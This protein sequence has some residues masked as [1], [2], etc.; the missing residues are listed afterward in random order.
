MKPS[1]L[2]SLLAVLATIAACRE[3]ERSD[4]APSA[5]AATVATPAAPS[6]VSVPPLDLNTPGI[7]GQ[8]FRAAWDAPWPLHR[9]V[10]LD[11]A[12]RVLVYEEAGLVPLGGDRY[13]LISSGAL[14]DAGHVDAGALSI[15]YLKYTPA[16][17]ERTGAWPEFTWDG[18]FGN[19]PTWD[20]RTDLTTDPAILTTG[21]G[22]WQGYSCQWSSL[23]ELTPQAPISRTETIPTGYDSAGAS[24]DPKAV[25]VMSATVLPDQKGRSF[26]VRYSGDRPASVTYGLQGERYVARTKPNLLTC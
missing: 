3:P 17:F 13:A 11:G 5:P 26:I 24:E 1:V 18:S 22:T 14:E 12:V 16:G 21:G 10:S 25:Q 9:K 2:I 20:A 19:P 15:H 4:T 8:A 6:E 7:E 23:I